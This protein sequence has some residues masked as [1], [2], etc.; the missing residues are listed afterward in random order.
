MGV[1]TTIY[2]LAVVCIQA[3]SYKEAYNPK[4]DILATETNPLLIIENLGLFFFALYCMDC[5]FMVRED[6]GKQAKRKNFM[7]VGVST[8]TICFV[9]FLA[10]GLMAYLSMGDKI[11]SLGIDIYANR[12]ALEGS[13]DMAMVI[14]KILILFTILASNI[15]RV[16][17]F[18]KHFFDM[19]GRELTKKANIIFTVCFMFLPCI[20]AFA[21]PEVLDWVGLCGAFCNSSLGVGF[22]ALMGWK[23]YWSKN[24]KPQAFAVAFW[25]I[26]VQAAF[27]MATF[28]TLL[29]MFGAYTPK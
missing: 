15:T 17:A 2:I 18:K 26:T 19:L 16:I 20:I 22:P 10:L 3:P 4:I 25:G 27:Y 14:G 6:M 5:Y 9:I 7:K 29:K 28:L 21:Y 8:V 12:P 1:A 23:Y 24:K 13:S 11:L